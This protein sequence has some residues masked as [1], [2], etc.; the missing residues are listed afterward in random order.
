MTTTIYN[1]IVTTINLSDD[2]NLGYSHFYSEVNRIKE[3]ILKIKDKKNR[4]IEE[5][6]IFHCTRGKT[7]AKNAQK[8][9]EHKFTTITN[10][11]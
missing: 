11:I 8:S 10:A 4:T 1:G 2:I 7:G 6:F 3:T 5:K 9:P